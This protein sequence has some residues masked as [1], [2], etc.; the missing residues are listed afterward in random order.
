M[1]PLSIRSLAA[2]ALS[3]RRGGRRAGSVVSTLLFSLSLTGCTKSPPPPDAPPPATVVHASPVTTENLPV[4]IAVNGTV[5]PVQRALIAAKVTGVIEQLPVALGQRVAAGDLLAQ[6]AAADLAARVAQTRT[7]L[8][9]TRR[10]LDRDT[11]LATGGAATEDAVRLSTDRVALAEAAL[12]EAET[13]LAYATLRAP[14]AGVVSRRL[15]HAG[16]LAS[17][18]QALVEIEGASAF[19]IEVPVPD[20]LVAHLA[21][22]AVLAFE[23]PSGSA[24]GPPASFTATVTEF[25]SASDT[26]A[27]TSFAKLAVPG[28]LAVRSGQFVRVFLPG[29]ATRTILAPTA[30]IT[31]FGQMERI[32]VV[33]ADRRASLRLV[34][35]GPRHGNR[36]EIVS[37]LDGSETIVLAPP[38]GLRDDQPLTLAP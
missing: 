5:R 28:D 17:P 25:S 23:L 30:A 19:E 3:G 4:L 10:D 33:T 6:L 20:S 2:E 12:R 29:D 37:G 27:R 7:T 15:V 14:F 9:Q 16:D 22:G 32:F 24:G 11:R 26:S 38:P 8:A 36:I 34:K 13:T 18:G 35:T 31:T 21:I 1:H